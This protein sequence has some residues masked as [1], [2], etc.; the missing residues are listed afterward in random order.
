MIF[1]IEEI[2]IHNYTDGMKIYKFVKCLLQ[3]SHL[4]YTHKSLLKYIISC[5]TMGG[6]Y[7]CLKILCQRV[8]LPLYYDTIQNLVTF[9]N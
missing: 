3:Q 6:L 7:H 2:R 1:F 9:Y 4:K 8:I 5:K